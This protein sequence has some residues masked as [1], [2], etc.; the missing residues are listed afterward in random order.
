MG[1]LNKYFSR[2]E[3]ICKCG[4]GFG[5][6]DYSLLSYLDEIRES[7]KRP[8]YLTSA[9]RCHSYNQSIGGKSNSAHVKGLAVDIKTENPKERFEV[10]QEIFSFCD[11]EVTRIGIAKDFIHMDIDGTKPQGVVWLY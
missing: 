1:N 6:I 7:I 5:N 2:S 8:L 11:P 3:V 10:L 4:C 9:C